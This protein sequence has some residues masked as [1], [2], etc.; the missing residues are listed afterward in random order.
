MVALSITL[1]AGW[2]GQLSLGQ[3]A[4]VGLGALT[5]VVLRAGLDIPVPFDL[6]DMQLAARLAP[7]VVVA[8]AVGRR[9]RAASSASRRCGSAA[10]SS[11]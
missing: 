5:M 2:A 3:F 7:A 10:C 9:C 8:T 6:C 1:L 4:F 11:R